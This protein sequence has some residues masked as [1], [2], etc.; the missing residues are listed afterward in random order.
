MKKKIRCIHFNTALN[1]NKKTMIY[2]N[3]TNKKKKQFLLSIIYYIDKTC[4]KQFKYIFLAQQAAMIQHKFFSFNKNIFFF[5]S[6]PN[7]L[8][9]LNLNNFTMSLILFIN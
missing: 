1:K 5:L 3:L 2:Y 8:N 6:I 7:L 9:K 4:L